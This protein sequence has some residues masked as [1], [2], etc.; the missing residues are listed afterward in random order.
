MK[1]TGDTVEEAI[2]NGL[3]ELNIPRKKAHITV[4]AREKR[5][6]LGFGK[7]PA[8]VDID[9]INETTVVKANQKAVR[10]V[11]SEINE[12]NEP[13]KS[14]SEATIDLG[15]VVA[16]V[17]EFEKSGQTLDDEIKAQILKNEKE[18]TTILEETGRIEILSDELLASV[19]PDPVVQEVGSEPATEA[20]AKDEFTDLDIKIEQQYDIET[21]V[22]EVTAYVQEILD[23]M[24]VEASIETSHNRRTINIQVDTNEP[25][26]VIGYHGKVLKALQLLAQ[27]FLYNRYERNFYITIN[28]NDYVEHRAEVL[29]GYAQKLA[30][31]VLAEQE[32]YHTDPMSS[33]ERKIIHRIISKMDGLTSYSEGSEPNRYVVVDIEGNRD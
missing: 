33:S 1:F 18:A 15:K 24:D 10:G 17:K 32:A 31:R 11:P 14:V 30:E 29:Q 4:I 13:V 21:V 8:T 16:A 2:Q 27:N 12:L 28:V 26:R 23:D 3:N 20:V 25:G 7:K 19:A 5:G 22:A 9:V 6:F